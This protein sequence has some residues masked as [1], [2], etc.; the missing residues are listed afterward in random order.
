MVVELK[1]EKR[2]LGKEQIK[3]IIPYDDSFLFIDKV[4]SLGKDKIEAVKEL[5]GDEYFFRGH[6][7]G[8]P[9]MPGAL[10]IEGIGQAAALL[11]RN[12]MQNPH[13][14][15]VLAYKLKDVKFISPIIPP[16]QLKFAVTLIAHD[17]KGAVLEGKAFVKENLVAECLLMLAIVNKSEFRARHGVLKK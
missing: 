9:L 17:D 11:V 2:E 14:K 7:I 4:T 16:A 13:E 15:D 3:Q 10:T 5:T 8:F 12:N 1:G 6:F